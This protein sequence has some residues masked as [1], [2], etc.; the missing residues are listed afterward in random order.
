MEYKEWIAECEVSS[1][2]SGVR[3][4]ERKQGVGWV[5][6]AGSGIRNSAC[7]E[8]GAWKMLSAE[9]QESGKREAFKRLSVENE[10]CGR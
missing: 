3:R 2:E 9:N 4:M 5:R 7:T 1:S 8:C 6:N 10:E